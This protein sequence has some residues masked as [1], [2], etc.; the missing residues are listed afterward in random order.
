MLNARLIRTAAGSDM[1]AQRQPH[2]KSNYSIKSSERR[3]AL[4]SGWTGDI[5][6]P[7]PTNLAQPTFRAPVPMASIEANNESV[8]SLAQ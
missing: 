2:Y 8:R 6:S 7:H 3:C 4:T 1:V 5:Y